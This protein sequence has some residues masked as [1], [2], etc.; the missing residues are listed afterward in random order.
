MCFYLQ[1][2]FTAYPCMDFGILN[3]KL[4]CSQVWWR[5]RKRIRSSRLV[6]QL[7]LY[8]TRTQTN[9]H[10]MSCICLHVCLCTLVCLVSTPEA[11]WIPLNQIC[12]HLLAG[13]QCRNRATAFNHRA[14]SL[15]LHWELGVVVY[16]FNLQREFQE[17]QSNTE[18]ACLDDK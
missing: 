7:G 2:C 13:M 18:K 17:S 8:E 12:R 3:T 5:Y 9:S 1:S 14:N 11:P 10:K 15:T 4:S 6:W 16:T